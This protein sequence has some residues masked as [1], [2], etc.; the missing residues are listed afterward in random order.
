MG[1]LTTFHG[2]P[3]NNV[4][5]IAQDMDGILWF[6][7][8]NGLAKYDG[9]RMQIF[10][11]QD[12]QN[13][14]PSNRIRAICLDAGKRL[15]I[16]ADQGCARLNGESFETLPETQGKTINSI[17]ALS[18]GQIVAV[19]QQG[20]V[21]R[22]TLNASGEVAEIKTLKPPDNPL[23]YS[24]SARNGERSPLPLTGAAEG[25]NDELLLASLRRG[26]P[27]IDGESVSEPALRPRPFYVEAIFKDDSRQIWIGAQAT[28]SDRGLFL[29]RRGYALSKLA[30][31][32]GTVTALGGGAD[33]ELWAGTESNGVFLLKGEMLLEHFTFENTAGGL[34]SN[35]VY[36]VFSDREGVVWFGTDR[37]VCRFDP[38]N[39]RAETLGQSS[40]SNFVRSLFRS[41]KGYLFCGTNR[42]LFVRKASGARQ[43]WVAIEDFNNRVV[44]SIG[45]DS[46]GRI[47]V[48]TANGLYYKADDQ[49]S[50]QQLSR[51]EETGNLPDSIRA[52]CATKTN[53]YVASFGHG[54]EAVNGDARCLVWP[55]ASDSDSYNR[56]ILSLFLSRDGRLWIGTA[57]AGIFYLDKGEVASFEVNS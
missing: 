7:T 4:R 21:Y 10:S 40:A 19:S 43:S 46:Q 53:L 3:S 2:L 18:S 20:E 56:Q 11:A 44:H 15:W 50:F 41:S 26:V 5:A 39:F 24:Q 9:R 23:L 45:E 25:R 34:R 47:W 29:W 8:D 55:P 12:G 6:G 32:T 1:A 13:K 48:G 17:I 27:S 28:R 51:E 37:G 22:I 57:S 42:G 31:R 30:L 54:L 14:L 33:G 52:I 35:R 49:S 36:T 16:G 38:G